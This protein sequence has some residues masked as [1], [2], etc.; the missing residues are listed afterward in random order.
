MAT[1]G[2]RSEGAI[3][4]PNQLYNQELFDTM[5]YLATVPGVI[6]LGQAVCYAGTGCYDSLVGVDHNKKIEMPVAENFQIGVSTGLALAGFTPIT[7]VP[8]WNFLLCATDQIVNHLDKLSSLSAG[9]SNPRVIIRVAQGSETPVD[10]QDQHKGDFSDAFALMCKN[11]NILQCHEP[12]QIRPHYDYALQ[13]SRS[14]IIVE[15]P[16][17]GKLL[18]A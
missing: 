5:A 6:F 3:L 10:P 8:R 2:C 15:Y 7:V 16:D 12:Q 1:C 4:T 17:Y 14:S 11:I 9:R 13:S 18:P